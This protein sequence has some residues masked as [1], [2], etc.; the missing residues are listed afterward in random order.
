ML[1]I[2][3]SKAGVEGVAGQDRQAGRQVDGQVDR[4]AG[5][6]EQVKG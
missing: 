1:Y 3:S 2:R 4:Q 5:Q 6:A